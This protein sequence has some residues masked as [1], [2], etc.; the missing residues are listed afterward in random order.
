MT[1]FSCTCEVCTKY[2]PKEMSTFENEERI[3]KIALH[4]LF[5]IKAEVDRVKQSIHDGRLWEYVIKKAHSHPKLFETISIFVENSDYF[6]DKTPRFKE[7][8]VFLF[9]KEDQFRPEITSFHKIVRKFKTK[10]NT[11]V[12]IPDGTIRP[13]YLSKEY[14]KLKRKFIKKYHDIQ[15][16]QFNPF[17]GI[18]PL[19]I[20]DIYPASHYVIPRIQYNPDEFPEFTKTWKMFFANNNFKTVYLAKD[21]FIKNHVKILTKKIK[22][23]PISRF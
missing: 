19:E 21:E 23:I 9:S 7:K 22:K 3:N 13:F 4:N 18:I 16:C 6:V 11:L 12:V 20:S 17:F 1:Y 8:A 14:N 2:T 15:F 5:A 10:K